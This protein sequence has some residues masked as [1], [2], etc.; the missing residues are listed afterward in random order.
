M[1]FEFSFLFGF[2]VTVYIYIYSVSF[3]FSDQSPRLD[4][5]DWP[6]A[7][8][9]AELSVENFED[10]RVPPCHSETAETTVVDWCGGFIFFGVIFA[11]F[12]WFLDGF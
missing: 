1:F 4:P 9:D 12:W 2:K 5:N 11:W 10:F 3:A 7:D 6:R 8:G